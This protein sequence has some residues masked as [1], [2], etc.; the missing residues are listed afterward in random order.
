MARLFYLALALVVFLIGLSFAYQNH[1]IVDLNYYFGWHWT[2]PLAEMLILALIIGVA[3]GYLVT[4]RRTIV[5]RSQ[6]AHARKQVKQVE[7]EVENLRSLPIKDV[8]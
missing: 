4:L 8:I 6:L 5:L 1:Q 2:A 3:I 7:Q